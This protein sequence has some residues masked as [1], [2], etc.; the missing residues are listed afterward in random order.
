MENPKNFNWDSNAKKIICPKVLPS[1]DLM[2]WLI[3][4]YYLVDRTFRKINGNTILS[5]Q[6]RDFKRIFHQK[7]DHMPIDLSAFLQESNHCIANDWS[8]TFHFNR[9]GLCT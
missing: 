6:V 4:P 1:P 7:L 3:Q 9:V 5:L 8:Y 2:Y